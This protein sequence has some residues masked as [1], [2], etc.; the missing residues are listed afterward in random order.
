MNLPTEGA[1][2]DD[3]TQLDHG[4]VPPRVMVVD[5]HPM[6]RDAVERDLSAAGI[7]IVA[8]AATGAEAINRARPSGVKGTYIKKVTLSSTMGPGVKLDLAAFATVV[9]AA[10]E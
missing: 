7:D 1:P 2:A 6:W 10:A 3:I 4:S 8:T 5:D 9:A